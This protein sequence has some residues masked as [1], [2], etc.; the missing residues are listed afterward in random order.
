MSTDTLKIDIAQQ[1]LGLSDE[2][3]LEKIRKL[4]NKEVVV[5]YNT[6]GTPITKAD[7]IEDMKKVDQEIQAG[8]L[9]IYTTEEVRDKIMKSR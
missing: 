8:T 6:D 4:L 3:L 1:I 5:G 7:F 9:K 2:K